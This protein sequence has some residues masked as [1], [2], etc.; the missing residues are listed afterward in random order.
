M[1]ESTLSSFKNWAW[2][3][4]TAQKQRRKAQYKNVGLFLIS[5]GVLL[6]F[7]RQ[8]SDLIYNQALLEESIK[9]GV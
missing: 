7:G 3:K 8:I 2:P 9:Q 6:K 1:S 5:T 4:D